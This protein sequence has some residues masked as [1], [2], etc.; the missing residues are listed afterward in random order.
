MILG[1]IIITIY[2]FFLKREGEKPE[3]SESKRITPAKFINDVA[4]YSGIDDAEAERMIE[5]VFNYFPGFNWRKNLPS[6]KNGKMDEGGK[7]KVKGD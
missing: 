7:R 4:Q 3:N 1:G 2:I 6:V 5:F